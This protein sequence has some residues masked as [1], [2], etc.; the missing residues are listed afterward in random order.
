MRSPVPVV[1]P[2]PT[3]LL[4]EAGDNANGPFS[5]PDPA[6]SVALAE[7]PRPGDAVSCA[8]FT[9]RGP[10]AGENLSL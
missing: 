3:R 10:F 2:F 7:G 9:S 4:L 5:W 1:I 8:A 6:L